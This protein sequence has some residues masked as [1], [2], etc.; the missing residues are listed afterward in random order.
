[1]KGIS[2]R[3]IFR[4]DGPFWVAFMARPDT[5]DGA[6]ELAR[7]HFAL[8]EDAADRVVYVEL[9]RRTF[10]KMIVA[11]T[12]ADDAESFVLKVDPDKPN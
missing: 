10:T 9:L 5:D 12:G 6:T 1:M 4:S 2:L 3:L 11:A 8:V 7:I